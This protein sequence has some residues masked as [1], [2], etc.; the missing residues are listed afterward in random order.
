[1]HWLYGYNAILGLFFLLHLDFL[2]TSC[3]YFVL[4]RAGTCI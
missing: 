1:L 4:V 2:H 3:N